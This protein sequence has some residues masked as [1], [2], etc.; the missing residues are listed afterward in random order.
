MQ[1]NTI[2]QAVATSTTPNASD[3]LEARKQKLYQASKDL[4]SIFLYHM[5]QSMR[6]TVPDNS[7]GV[8]AAGSGF[9][10]DV[11]TQM[12]DQ[13]LASKMAGTGQRSLADI[14][15]GNLE[16]VLERQS[17]M[18]PETKEVNTLIEPVKKPLN[19]KIRNLPLERDV[20][21][22]LMPPG[23]SE[24]VRN[25][26]PIIRQAAIKYDLDPQLLESV[27]K[28][29][30]G[31]DPEAVSPA[32]AKGLMQLTDTTAVEVGVTDVFDPEENIM[33]GAKYLRQMLNRF[34]DIRTALAAYNAG[35]GTV[36]KHGGVPP[37]QET[38]NYINKIMGQSETEPADPILA[39][40]E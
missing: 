15:Y 26:G 20:P 16:K 1:V 7:D 40:K 14:L 38:Q 8:G 3:T 13:E 9:G 27:I 28:A 10:K 23:R 31:G 4:E 11:Y 25:F 22:K 12:F 35:P 21:E 32:G 37:Y 39:A 36:K 30:S 17:G 6:K 29:E 19:L 34:G 5:L 18:I 33:G 24:P 2:A